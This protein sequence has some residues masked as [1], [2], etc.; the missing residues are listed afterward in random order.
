MDTPNFCTFKREDQI[1]LWTMVGLGVN[2]DENH[3]TS[4]T[5]MV[6]QPK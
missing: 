1:L 5:I 4:L 6:E 3:W 2:D